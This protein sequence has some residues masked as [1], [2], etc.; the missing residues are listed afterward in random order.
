MNS[1]IGFYI[2]AYLITER[3]ERTHTISVNQIH[4]YLFDRGINLL[5]HWGDLLGADIVSVC[6][7][8][9]TT[10]ARLVTYKT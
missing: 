5:V 6:L 7:L 1:N 2:D 10:N 8:W 9:G 3:S 4:D